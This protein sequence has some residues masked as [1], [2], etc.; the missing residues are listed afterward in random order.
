MAS[1]L[2]VLVLL[3]D[4]DLAKPY[5]VNGLNKDSIKEL[6]Q[7]AKD[8]MCPDYNLI[9]VMACEGGCIGGNESLLPQRDAKKKI[10]ELTDSSK[11]IKSL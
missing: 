5:I 11:D 3:K 1:A 10:K 6:K 2:S 7:F 8:K 9:E 4:K